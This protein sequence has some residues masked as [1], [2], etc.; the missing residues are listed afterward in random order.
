MCYYFFMQIDEII[1]KIKKEPQYLSLKNVVE[2]NSYHTNQ[3][4]YD[5]SLEVLERAKEFCSGNFIENEEAKKLFKEF[6]NQEVGG[7]KIIDSMLLV[8]LL[9]DISKGARYKDNNEQEQVVLKTLPNGNTSGYMHE[10]VSSLLAPQLLKYKGLS[11]EAVN[12]VCKIIK[13]H[14]AFNEDY[15]KMVS[16]WPIEQIVDN[17]KLRAEGVYIEALFNIYCDCFT[18]EPFQFALETIKKIFESPSFYTKR[19]FYF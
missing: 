3:A 9:H 14:D 7:L 10:Y 1:N 11:E 6:T 4:T 15:F 12:H 2:N 18:A 5:H 13:L 16:D 8:A 17:V 19:T